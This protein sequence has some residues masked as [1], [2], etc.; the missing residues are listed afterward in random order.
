MRKVEYE[1]ITG[2][3][4]IDNGYYS[5]VV[6]NKQRKTNA[7]GKGQVSSAVVAV[8]VTVGVLVGG[9]IACMA[10][11]NIPVDERPLQ[12]VISEEEESTYLDE[13]FEFQNEEQLKNAYNSLLSKRVKT[14]ELALEVLDETKDLELPD[15][16]EEDMIIKLSGINNNVLEIIELYKTADLTE[17]ERE[18]VGRKIVLAKEYA[19]SWL[20]ESGLETAEEL[21]MTTIKSTV[22]MATGTDPLDYDSWK[23][24]Y[25]SIDDL[26]H[27]NVFYTGKER[28]KVRHVET[29]NKF[30]LK[31]QNQ[32]FEIQSGKATDL[33]ETAKDALEITKLIVD[34]GTPV[35]SG[36]K[37]TMTNSEKEVKQLVK[38][39]A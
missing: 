15:K 27:V 21:L 34:S 24:S 1:R 10:D 23:I 7:K 20:E 3:E 16:S 29:T 2:A 32:I 36:E 35:L 33:V 9:T 11:S 26:G 18:L 39:K 19:E 38:S 13:I 12:T 5:S 37:L 30:L 17:K 14:M 25:E 22:A 31:A 8:C 28:T 6:E 4:V